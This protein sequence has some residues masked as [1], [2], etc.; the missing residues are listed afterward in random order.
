PPA[1]DEAWRPPPRIAEFR[2]ER[3]LGRGASAQVWLAHDTL[4]D[5]PVAL[6]ISAHETSDDARAR[7]RMEALAVARLQHPN[8]LT[9]HQFG[10]LAGR[11]YL[12]TEVLRGRT[13][14]SLALPLDPARAAAIAIDLARGLSAA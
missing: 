7:F 14:A 1:L 11:P 13:L 9:V 2:L 6:K 10:E 12:V 4:L 8:V 3:L 5:R